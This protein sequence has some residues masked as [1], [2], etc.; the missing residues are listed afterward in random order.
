M[1][2]LQINSMLIC[3]GF[4]SNSINSFAGLVQQGKSVVCG[5][6]IS[7]V[8]KMAILSCLRGLFSVIFAVLIT[9]IVSLQVLLFLLIFRTREKAAQMG[10]RIWARIILAVSGVRVRVEGMERLDPSKSYI[11]V[12][13]HQSQ[14]DIFCLQGCLD[15]DFRWLAKKEL[16]QIPVFGTALRRSGSIPIDRSSGRKAMRSLAEAAERIK[17]GCSVIIFPEGTRSADGE[18]QAFKVGGMVIAIKAGV[19][20]V[21]MAISGSRRVLA[22]GRVLPRSGEVVIRLGEPVDS[23]AYGMKEK[24]ELADHLRSQVADLLSQ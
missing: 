4:E 12:A 22:K 9:P 24:Q 10:P 20:V 2:R 7:R 23:R 17:K 13:N 18:L 21:P 16:F 1:A 6:K 8:K 14:F 15:W 3:L 11:F 19:G 5:P